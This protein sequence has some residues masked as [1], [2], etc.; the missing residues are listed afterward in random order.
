MG[1]PERG[2][3][4]RIV[5]LLIKTAGWLRVHKDQDSLLYILSEYFYSLDRVHAINKAY[6]KTIKGNIVLADRFPNSC[7]K[8][9]DGPYYPSEGSKFKLGDGKVVLSFVEKM[10][11][12]FI[13]GQISKF[14]SIPNPD[15]F[16]YLRVDENVAVNRKAGEPEEYVRQR[17]RIVSR[18]IEGIGSVIEVDSNLPE[19]DVLKSLKKVVWE[20]L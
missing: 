4:T 17:N 7:L 20:T 13:D 16:I 10:S 9:V 11:M 2:V 6:R 19:E 15:V 5:N 1:K 3:G 18:S 8:E 14:E 12:A